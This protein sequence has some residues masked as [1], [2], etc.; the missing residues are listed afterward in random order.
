MTPQ[1]NWQPPAAPPRPKQADPAHHSR[2]PIYKRWWFIVGAVLLGTFV[3]AAIAAGQADPT[4]SPTAPAEAQIQTAPAP[5]TPEQPTPPAAAPADDDPLSDGG[6]AASDIQ[7]EQDQFG[8]G[9]TA[10]VTN[11]EGITRTGVFTLTVFSDG[12]RIYQANGAANA[13]EAGQTATVTFIGSTES[14]GDDPSRFTYQF[15]SD[16]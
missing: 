7:I 12:Q 9:I 10:Q 6:W 13:V 1:V 2:K 15:Q 5:I 8:T 3:A 16:F 11:T 4:S 14:I